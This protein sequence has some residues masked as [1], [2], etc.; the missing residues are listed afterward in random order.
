MADRMRRALVAIAGRRAY[1][2]ERRSST[3]LALIS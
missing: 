3:E 1:C 2:P